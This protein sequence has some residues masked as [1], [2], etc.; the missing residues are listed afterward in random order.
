[1]TYLQKKKKKK[2]CDQPRTPGLQQGTELSEPLH[3][4]I[5]VLQITNPNISSFLFIKFSVPTFKFNQVN[6]KR[7]GKRGSRTN[8]TSR[9]VKAKRTA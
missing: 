4:P 5:Q 9:Q 1:M 8:L 7:R 2:K 6:P 3:H